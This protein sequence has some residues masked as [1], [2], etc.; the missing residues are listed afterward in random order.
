[1]LAVWKSLAEWCTTI[2]YQNMSI[3]GRVE[4]WPLTEKR[5]KTCT[6]RHTH[7]ILLT[8]FFFHLFNNWSGAALSTDETHRIEEP[9]FI[10]QEAIIYFFLLHSRIRFST[11]KLEFVLVICVKW[12]K[13]KCFNRWILCNFSSRCHGS[14]LSSFAV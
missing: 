4:I 10:E 3:F 7:Q 12:F 6:H 11:H 8:T 5:E 13:I 9:L 2:N 14:A 1:M